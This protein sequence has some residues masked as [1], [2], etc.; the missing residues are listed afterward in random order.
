MSQIFFMS[1]NFG[2]GAIYHKCDFLSVGYFYNLINIIELC[3]GMQL[4]DLET[5]CSFQALLLRFVRQDWNSVS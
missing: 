1:S 3:S 2:L 5:L 4:N